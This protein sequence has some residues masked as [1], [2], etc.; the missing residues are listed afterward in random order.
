LPLLSLSHIPGRFAEF[1]RAMIRERVIA[2]LERAREQGKPLGRRPIAPL[3]V[4][5]IES[6]ASGGLSVRA[7]AR[8]TDVSVGTVH[9]VLHGRHVTQ[10]EA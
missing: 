10:V 9:R 5:R 4:G 7:I 1:E 2:G 3:V 8:K 6:A